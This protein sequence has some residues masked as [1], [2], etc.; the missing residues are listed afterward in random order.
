[1]SSK[2]TI[3]KS[4]QIIE[5]SYRLSLNEQRVILACISQVNSA[6]K[7]ISL[8]YQHLILHVFFQFPKK[9]RIAN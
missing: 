5:A 6:E 9:G 8:N 2:L 7:L 1:M 3:Y 4:N